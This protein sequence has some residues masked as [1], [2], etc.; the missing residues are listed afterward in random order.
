MRV[1]GVSRAALFAPVLVIG[2]L[3]VAVGAAS[4]HAE[5]VS[6]TPGPFEIWTYAPSSVTVTVSEAVQPGSA[7]ILVTNLTG[8]RVDQGATV[9]SPADPTTFSVD[10]PG[11]GPSVYTVTWSAISAD[12]GH[13]D[14]G[15]FY[16]IVRNPDG[17]LPGP[18]PQGS[19]ATSV[20]LVSPLDVALRALQFGGF[21]VAFGTLMFV[22]LIW[23]P[24]RSDLKGA[25]AGSARAAERIL[26]RFARWGALVFVVAVGASW[27]G[28]LLAAPPATLAGAVGSTYLLSSALRVAFG[29]AFLGL[30]TGTLLRPTPAWEGGGRPWTLLAALVVGLA[31]IL[32][33]SF[34]THSAIVEEGWPLGPLADAAH[35]YGVALWVGGLLAVVRVRGPLLRSLSPAFAAVALEAFSRFAMLAVVLVVVAGTALGVLLVG[36]LGALVDT[37]YGWVVLAKIGLLVPMVALGT[38]NRRSLARSRADGSRARDMAPVARRVRAEAALGAGVLVLAGLLTSLNPAALPPANPTFTLSGTDAGLYAVFQVFPY[39]SGPGSYLFT[40]EAWL[41]DNGSNVIDVVNG[42]A[43]LT[44]RPPWGGAPQTVTMEGPHGLNHFYY[45][46]TGIL[47]EAGTWEID[48]RVVR[49]SGPVADFV[50]RVTLRG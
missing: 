33:E 15:T 50:F 28:N 38:W 47:S 35:L 45:G 24:A 12:D 39:P 4:A 19:G 16:F 1:G 2:A 13:F 27:A 21:S 29:L 17:T 8:S 23:E 18:F 9:L 20:E 25:E 48:A 3:L 22:L 30:V 11:I 46:P 44:F 41:A 31:A 43:N 36:S 49:T 10:T 7:L 40:L 42:S 14:V 34:A 5:F 37:E 32:A 26:L 6:S